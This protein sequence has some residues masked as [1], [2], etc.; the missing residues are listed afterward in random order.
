MSRRI[1]HIDCVGGIAGDMLVSALCAAAGSTE[2]VDALPGKLGIDDVRLE[3]SEARP[4]GFAAHRLT[5]RFEAAAHPHHRGLADVE[6]ILERADLAGPVRDRALAVF[7]RMAEA[8]SRVHGVP[9]DEMHFHEVGAVDALIDV[10]AACAMLESLGPEEVVC[11]PLPMGHG[12]VECAHGTLPLPSPAVAAM[13]V[14]VPVREVDVRG[15][16]VTPTGA[17]LATTLA[18]RFGSMPSMTVEAMGVGGGSREF[19]GLANVVRVFV[20]SAGDSERR[21]EGTANVLVECNVDDL[22]P[23]VLPTVI[24]RLLAAGALDAYVTPIVMKK[25]RPGHLITALAAPE[26]S[27]AA[28]QV[29]LRDTTSLGCR[30]TPVTKR[31]LERRMEQAVTPWGAVPVKVALLEGQVLRRMPEFDACAELAKRAGVPVRDV[32]AAAGATEGQ[33]D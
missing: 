14:G 19:E 13:L 5:V 7:R 12:T 20:G 15:E 11:S 32:L 6:A 1:V 33:D 16:T 31:E 22:D 28:V 2:I 23:R 8:E 27:E 21:A 25:G 10:A 9:I 3:W 26:T 24:E 4:G 30:I 18:D 29:L 17:A